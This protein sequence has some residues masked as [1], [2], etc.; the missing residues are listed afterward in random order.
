MLIRPLPWSTNTVWPLKKIITGGE[1]DA[2]GISLD[3]AAAWRGDVEARMWRTC[4]T[5]E[6][7]PHTEAAGEST[8]RRQDEVGVGIV[9]IAPMALDALDGG[10]F[11]LDAR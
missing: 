3:G 5:V 10:D 4:L 11:A 6:K 1:H 9:G 7:A 8:R 2:V